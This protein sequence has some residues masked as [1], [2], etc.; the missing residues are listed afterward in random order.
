[1][2][3][4]GG[5]MGRE[6]HAALEN[7]LPRVR[8][9]TDRILNKEEAFGRNAPLY[10]EIG[11]GSGEFLF[12][13]ALNAPAS[14]FIGIDIFRPGIAKLMKRLVSSES[15]EEISV[16]N[17]RVYD[18][19]A[20]AVLSSNI[21]DNSLDGVHILFPDPW[22]KSKHRKRRLIDHGL[23]RLIHSLLKADGYALVVT[24]HAEYAADIEAAFKDAGFTDSG[25]GMAGIY[26][27]KYAL[28]ASRNKSEVREYRFVK[29]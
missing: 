15:P 16:T 7:V 26:S 21:P 22:P 18:H 14:D 2:G 8:L 11:F 20:R 29:Q 19:N 3:R 28:K 9:S 23:A 17:I 10:L 27:T 25:S 13:T 12:E 24:D 5:R 1:M 6:S 4:K